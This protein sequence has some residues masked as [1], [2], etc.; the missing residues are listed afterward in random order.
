MFTALVK[1]FFIW[2]IRSLRTPM[3]V[4]CHRRQENMTTITI[5]KAQI[6]LYTLEVYQSLLV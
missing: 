3:T 5:E 2:A 1:T 4:P 6:V